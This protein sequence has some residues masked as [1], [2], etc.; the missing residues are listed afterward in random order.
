[1]LL[2]PSCCIGCLFNIDSSN[3]YTCDC[4]H[5]VYIMIHWFFIFDAAVNIDD[6]TFMAEILLVIA[7]VELVFML[8]SLLFLRFSISCLACSKVKSD[9][10][11]VL[12]ILKSIRNPAIWNGARLPDT[13]LQILLT[14]AYVVRSASLSV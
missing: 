7:I 10:I 2:K 4:I 1:M 13:S 8:A 11:L 12:V 3:W 6:D 14:V 9:H 5:I